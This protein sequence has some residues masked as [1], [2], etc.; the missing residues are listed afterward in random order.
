MIGAEALASVLELVEAGGD[1]EGLVAQ[2]ARDLQR[3][4]TEP[5]QPDDGDALC[6]ADRRLAQARE[7]DVPGAEQ[8][9]G[10]LGVEAVGEA[11]AP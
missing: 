2:G 3:Q 4:V 1:G 5:S 7:R 9:S 8:G 10:E 6:P 11:R